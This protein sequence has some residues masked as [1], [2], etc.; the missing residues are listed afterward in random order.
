MVQRAA[1]RRL[2]AYLQDQWVYVLPAAALLGL[3][4]LIPQFSLFPVRAPAMLETHL[5]EELFSI[6]VSLMVAVVAWHESEQRPERDSGLMIGGFVAVAL[7]DL[8]HA[9]SYD[10]MPRLIIENSTQRAIFF[11]LLGRSFAAMTIGLIA[12]G[13]QPR[14]TRTGWLLGG[15]A[16]AGLSLAAG[17]WW[18]DSIP[19]LYVPG[20]GLTLLKRLWEYA[21]V[22]ADLSTALLFILR[23]PAQP[24][25]QNKLFAS[26]CVIMAMGEVVFANYQ[27][28]S[29]FLNS[30][31]HL[32]KVLAYCLLYQAVF[33]HAIRAP[34]ERIRESEERF[35][36]LTEL[37]SDWFWMVDHELRFTEVS[38]GVA[39]ITTQPLLGRH[40]WELAPSGLKGDWQH[41]RSACA[42]GEALRLLRLPFQSEAG[43]VRW[44]SVS[45][46]PIRNDKGLLLGYRGVCADVTERVRNEIELLE[47]SLRDPLTRLANLRGLEQHLA[48]AQLALH[49]ERERIAFLVLNVDN[50]RTFNELGHAAGDRALVQ[51]ALRLSDALPAPDA[52]GHLGA[53][54]FVAIARCREGRSELAGLATRLM[55]ALRRPI[56]VDGKE[57]DVTLSIGLAVY[58]DEG[59]SFDQL[60]NSADLAMRR[61]KKA[62]KDTYRIYDDTL[63]Q[64]DTDRLSLR[65]ALR[66]ALD[67]GQFELHYQPQIALSSGR[68]VGA[69]A[70]IRWNH[71][72][73]GLLSPFHFIAA[74][75]E[76]GLIIPIDR[77][78]LRAACQRAAEWLARGLPAL[79]IAVNCSAL[80]FHRGTLA[81]DVAEALRSTGLPPGQ[82]E[83]ELT[84]SVLAGEG[85]D[86]DQLLATASAVKALGVHL[87]IDDFGTGY[88]NFRYLRKLG[89][90]K[91][92]IDQSFVRDMLTDPDDA[93]IVQTVC[94]LAS[95]LGMSA[96][97]EGV[98][99][100]DIAQKLR[101]I[102]C[103]LAQGYYLG[104]PMP[105]HE[106]ASLLGAN[107]AAQ[108]PTRRPG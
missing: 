79:N 84:E 51:I 81:E 4:G 92:K 85:T 80:Q 104:R 63:R 31:G 37:S 11:W 7:I 91:L 86:A 66:Q 28:P 47:R 64:A 95:R 87:A 98:E 82:L 2:A 100:A 3:A 13:W 40:P 94:Q 99:T 88:S 9:L 93:N 29:D 103:E 106:L 36:A 38:A 24:A 20:H 5:L 58:P 10:G 69:E 41:Y 101:L 14:L 83:L 43:E 89:I 46:S 48:A 52:V 49:G 8:M 54:E 1:L 61:A 76:F 50:F 45:S 105:A 30:F 21:L 108:E 65:N 102:G 59:G 25:A 42:A 72:E 17:T 23:P 57:C 39:A 55:S 78:V 90:D 70:L 44:F 62:G 18:I 67:R 96:I 56:V 6:I 16:A 32:Y 53:D 74:A 12:L 107:A 97:A 68:I 19:A 15:M 27:S 71:P 60:R 26:S 33:V 22:A 34:Y 73:R 75:E 77:W 35:R